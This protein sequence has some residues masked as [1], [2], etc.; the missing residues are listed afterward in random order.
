[1]SSIE[2]VPVVQR[3]DSSCTA[4]KC[5]DPLKRTTK[6]GTRGKDRSKKNNKRKADKIIALRL[7]MQRFELKGLKVEKSDAQQARRRVE[8]RTARAEGKLKEYTQYR[9]KFH[10]L[11]PKAVRSSEICVPLGAN[12]ANHPF[13]KSLSLLLRSP[14]P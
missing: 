14:H 7:N 8:I 10:T 6:R 12:F 9:D 5:S 4:L 2:Q 11:E 1:M 3:S 13:C